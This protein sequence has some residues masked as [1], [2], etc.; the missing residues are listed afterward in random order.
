MGGRPQA[1]V[2]APS[3]L[4][5]AAASGRRG[6]QAGLRLGCTHFPFLAPRGFSGV[7]PRSSSRCAVPCRAPPRAQSARRVLSAPVGLAAGAT[8]PS[9][10]RL[11]RARRSFPSFE[12]SPGLGQGPGTGDLGARGRARRPSGRSGARA[13]TARLW[14][15]ARAARRPTRWPRQAWPAAPRDSASCRW[16]PEPTGVVGTP[17]PVLVKTPRAVKDRRRPK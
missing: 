7:F 17:R 4:S 6:P 8:D 1:G 13:L 16:A 12:I 14:P 3:S 5:V 15:E 11:G 2:S 10:W 9:P